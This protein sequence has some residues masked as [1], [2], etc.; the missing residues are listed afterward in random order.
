MEV[1]GKLRKLKK[2]KSMFPIDLPEQIRKEFSL[3]LSIPL[4]NIYNS[5]LS[6]GIF[7]SIWKQELVTPVPK[8]EY[9][10][11]IK[12]TRKI[13][14]LS[15][16]CKIYEGFLKKWILDDISENESFRQFGGKKGIGAEHMLVCMVDRILKLLDTA[17]GR[18][19]V[20]RS[21]Y[22]WSNAFDRQDP[23]KTVQKFIAMGIR[24]SLIPVL[25]DFLSGRSM[26]IKYNGKQAGP[27][28]LVG[29]S[30]Q[31]SFLGQLAYTTGSYDNTEQLNIEEEDKFQYIDD[32]DL[33]ELIILTDVL[34]QYDFRAHVA[35]DIAIGQRFLP[36]SSTKTQTFHDGIALWTRQ[37]MMKLNS[38]KSKYVLHTRMQEDFATRLTLDG[39]HIDRQK[40]T[41]ILGLG[42][43]EDPSS[44]EYNTTEIIKK[45]YASLSILTKL[46]YAGLSR[47][48]LLHIYCLHVRSSMVLRCLAQQPN[49]SPEQ[50]H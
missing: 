46:K 26:H 22:D 24:P 3:E 45:T 50:C 29:G 42:I 11:E 30:P 35:S 23:T 10:K 5:C 25:I 37:N 2:T 31:G 20:I 44:W 17:E 19:L 7:P 18:A 9:L 12:D 49:T 28:K 27:F 32:L 16:F 4:V 13:S 8:K 48:K 15:D 36:P 34:I 21:Q 38:G 41:K 47:T 40:V 43:G 6:Q 33:L 39:C 1:W 14:C